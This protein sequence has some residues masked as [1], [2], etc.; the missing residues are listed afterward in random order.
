MRI[1]L[2]FDE[3]YPFWIVD[4]VAAGGVDA[5]GLTRDRPQLV[6]AND[7]E[8]LRAAAA[9]GRVVVTEDI[10]TFPAAIAAVPNHVGVI[11][12]RAASYPRTRPGM[13]RLAEALVA[14]LTEPP[15]GLGSQP[16]EWWL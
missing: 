12:V 13:N 5:V 7:T 10:R 14:L 3:H 16:V 11:F 2:L 1:A 8:V 4:Q 6:E 9:E 15:E